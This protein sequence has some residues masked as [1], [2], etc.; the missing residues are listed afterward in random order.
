[1]QKIS[2]A[3]V[4]AA[5]LAIIMGCSDEPPDVGKIE[6]VPEQ[7]IVGTAPAEP[8]TF[9]LEARLWRGPKEDRL[10]IGEKEGYPTLSWKVTQPWLKV[11]SQHGLRAIIEVQKGAVASAPGFVRAT[12]GNHTTQP[13]AR[14]TVVP[15][16]VPGQ[17]MVR[18]SYKPDKAP[19]VVFAN[20]VRD[21]SGTPCRQSLTT[22]V[23]RA[24][25]GKLIARCP[26]AEGN[27]GAA[28]LS[29]DHGL[30]FTTAG[31]T[32]AD[33]LVDATPL[34]G[35]LRVL[36]LALHI[37]VGDNSLGA[38]ALAT[39]RDDALQF[40]RKEVA[41][42]SSFLA[43]ARAGI[44]LKIAQTTTHTVAK[45]VTIEGC[46]DGDL[47]TS[48]HDAPGILNVYYV[49]SVGAFRGLTCA[50]HDGRQQEVVYV[51]LDQ[52][53]P[54]TFVHE[55]GH[56]L[57]SSLPHEGH[58]DRMRGFDRTNLMTGGENDY[59]SEGRRRYTAGQVFRMNADS[60]SWLNW[61]LD[62]FDPGTQMQALDPLARP[63]RE[64]SAARLSCQCSANDSPG[65]CPP[66]IDDVVKPSGRPGTANSWQCFDEL[67][68]IRLAGVN[69]EPV[70][71]VSGRPWGEPPGSC[72]PDLFGPTEKH[73]GQNYVRFRNLTRAGN[74]SSSIAIFF[75]NYGVR[76][77]RL[78]EPEVVWTNSAQEE[79]VFED[80][81]PPATLHITVFYP[82]S[83]ASLVAKDE[84]H[85]LKT[86]GP[87]NR[88]GITIDF[89]LKPGLPCKN[90]LGTLQVSL[91]Y[92]ALT[93]EGLLVGERYAEIS[94]VNR[95]P[96]AASHFL[97]RALG[98]DALTLTDK[99]FD[100]NIMKADAQKRGQR[101][102]LGQVFRIN[103]KLQPALY[104]CGADCPALSADVS[105][106]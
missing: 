1:M 40:A 30:L 4:I 81:P 98:L 95:G 87:A 45:W 10:S 106:E 64:K 69:D 47:Q 68:L 73:E 56:V 88:S 62:H 91:C 42:A 63:V 43:E 67:W 12:S 78:V 44:E 46:L 16:N 34:E 38:G 39:Q 77:R 52:E 96:T 25:L 94:T 37:M 14:I 15:G 93:A 85:I 75:Q 76:Y 92:R 59:D 83:A 2:Q 18:T 9:E 49:N 97:G 58:P 61:S 101:L 48:A 32:N 7:V 105:G 3:M 103:H 27:W 65:R 55:L 28:F 5:G 31:W 19:N 17:D 90:P 26:G 41:A 8:T 86:Y 20:G 84:A 99:V 74:C 53:W 36:P 24:P 89:V 72:R 80:M 54:S 23:R 82:I 51:G 71:L 66:L 70:A 35:S 33:D 11:K 104:P 29:I 21:A 100:N 13:G 6:V 50:W 22:F 102:T 57:G 60:A 79:K